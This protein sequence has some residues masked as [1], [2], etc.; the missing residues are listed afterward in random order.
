MIARSASSLATRRLTFLTPGILTTATATAT[1]AAAK[2]HLPSPRI[3]AAYHRS[4]LATRM[5]STLPRLP[6]LEAVAA[7]D[8][9]STAVVH[10]LSRRRFTYGQ[11][12]PDVAAARDRLRDATAGKPLTGERVAFLIENS[13]D[14]VGMLVPKLTNASV[15]VS[16]TGVL[17]LRDMKPPHE[18]SHC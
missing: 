17:I 14:Y 16:L 1:A 5:L 6:I 10:A 15:H 2:R 18:R 12:L 8:P 7:H 11:L 4:C 9:E 3:P 13:Y